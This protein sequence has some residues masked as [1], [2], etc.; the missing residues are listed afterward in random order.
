MTDDF[1]R[2]PSDDL[3]DSDQFTAPAASSATALPLRRPGTRRLRRKDDPAQQATSSSS[4]TSTSSISLAVGNTA[5][6]KPLEPGQPRARQTFPDP[7]PHYLPFGSV[8]TL[9]GA[10]GTGKTA[11]LASQIIKPLLAGQPILGQ[12]TNPPPAI[13]I[14]VCDRPWRD[15]AAWLIKAGID[16]DAIPHV[17]LRDIVNYNWDVLRDWKAIPKVFGSLVDTMHL[18][19]GSLLIVDPLPL[20]V[21]GRLIDYKDVAIGIGHLD[22]QL[23]PRSLTLFG[24]FH[25]AKQKAN[26]AERYQ[27]PQ[28][29]ILGST[30]L[31][32][33][34]ETA[35]FLLSPEEAE[36][37]HYQFGIV[38]HQQPGLVLNYRRTDTGLF[39]PVE[40]ADQLATVTALDTCLPVPGVV[41]SSSVLIQTIKTALTC[42]ENTARAHIRDLMS[43][44]L[45]ASVG[46]G[47]YARP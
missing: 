17:S 23:R 4:S 31:I 35:M 6:I 30:A 3:A 10:S 40:E 2:D 29:R 8:C 13:G 24:V 32:G 20:F 44:G 5:E 45:L 26:K 33:Y 34:S 16:P 27:R 46:R 41:V 9:S 42:G 18:P 12:T 47:L 36:S 1:D 25:T 11:F 7:I 22:Q 37:Q 43:Q 38:A 15:H 39:A 14:L 28:D 21:P 19:P